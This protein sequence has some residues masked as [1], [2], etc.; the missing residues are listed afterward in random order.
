[1]NTKSVTMRVVEG[2]LEKREFAFFELLISVN[3]KYYIFV[4]SDKCIH[5]VSYKKSKLHNLRPKGR[6]LMIFVSLTSDANIRFGN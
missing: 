1:M 5:S 4:I 3:S 2:F 6:T